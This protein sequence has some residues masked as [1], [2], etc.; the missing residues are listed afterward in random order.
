MKSLSE[1]GKYVVSDELITNIK[2]YFAAGCCS[3][4]AVFATIKEQFEKYGYLVDTHTSV[5][6]RV[7]NDYVERTGD[8]VPTVIDSTASPYKFSKSVLSAV[9][10]GNTPDMSEFDMVY[11]LNRVTG[12]DIPEPLKALKD[13]AVRFNNV[14]DRENMSEMVFRLLKI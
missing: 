4:E 7:Y 12:V 13:K 9:L 5:A 2:K 1:R 6:V 10:G 8:D 3:E 11:E 14:C